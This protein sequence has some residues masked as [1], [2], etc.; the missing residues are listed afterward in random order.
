[1]ALYAKGRISTEKAMADL[2]HL[3][4]MFNRLHDNDDD[5]EEG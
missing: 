3:F 1:M 4:E 5:D 2:V